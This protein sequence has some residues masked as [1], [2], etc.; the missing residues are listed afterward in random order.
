M[1][2]ALAPLFDLA[3]GVVNRAAAAIWPPR[4]LP[5]L[6]HEIPVSDAHRTLVVVPTLLT[7]PDSVRTVLEHLE[8]H[9]LANIDDNIHFALLGDLKAS[10]EEHASGDAAILEASRSGVE[11]LNERHGAGSAGPFHL[12]VRSRLYNPV[13]SVWMGWERKRGSLTELGRLLRGVGDTSIT[14]QS[15]DSSFLQGVEFVITLDADTIL[16]RD[17]A[18]KLVCTIAHPLSR[19]QVDSGRRGVSR[20]YGLVQPRVGMSL[21][22]AMATLYSRL[23]TGSTGLDPYAGAASDTYQDVFGEGSFTGKG[24]FEVDVF[25]AILEGR[26]PDNRLLSH[27]LIEGCFLRTALVSDVEVLDD[28]PASYLAQSARVHR[29]VRGDWQLLPWL[30]R[31]APGS[32]GARYRNPLSRLHRWKIL[33]NLRRS[34]FPVALLLLGAAGW[35]L[36]PRSGWVWP[37]LLLLVLVFDALMHALDSLLMYPRGVGFRGAIRPVISDLYTDLLRSFVSLSV[38]PHQAYLQCDAAVRALWRSYV[39]K[40]HLLEWTTA[41]EAESLSGSDLRSFSRALLVPALLAVLVMSPALVFMPSSRIFIAPAVITWLASPLVA[42]SISRPTRRDVAA[43]SEADVRY[44]R[45]AARKTW[46][47]FETFVTLEDHW[48]VPDNYQED[49]KGEI[50]HRTSPT[51]MGLQLI[52]ELTAHDLGYTS[53]GVMVDRVSY[54][55]ATMIGLER[56]RGHLYNWYDTLTLEPLRPQYVSTVDSGNLA[57]HLLALRAGLQEV[58]AGPIIGPQALDGFGDALEVALESLVRSKETLGQREIVDGVRREIE[59]LLRRI[60]LSERPHN[61]A[62]WRSTLDDMWR[63]MEPLEGRV[64]GL[65]AADEAIDVVHTV[66]EAVET[67]RRHREDLGTYAPWARQVSEVPHVVAGWTRAFDLAPLLS[68]VPSLVDLAEGLVSTLDALESLISDPVGPDEET[69]AEVAEWATALARDIR[70]NRGPCVELLA[71]LRLMSDVSGEMWAH[72]DF[73]MLYDKGR[74]LFSIGFNMERGE[75]DSSFYDMLASEC[76]LA[77]YLAIAKGEVPQEHWFRLGRQFTRTAGGFALLSWSASMFEYL[78]PQLV[79]N[80]YPDTVLKTT[81]DVVVRR[82]VQYGAERGVP[83]GVSE[84]AFAAKDVELTYQ[85]QAFGVPGLGLK[86]GLSDDVVVAPYAT[87]LALQV[88]RRASLANLRRLSAEG[89]EGPYGF[90][91]SLDYTPGRVPAGK[92]RA[93]VRAYMAHHQGM[94]IVALGNELT[95]GRMRLRFHS[96]P[97]VETAELL[98]QERIPRHIKAAQP[99]VEEVEFVRSLREL[100]PPVTRSYPLANTP[101]PATHFLSNGRYSVMVT[102]AGAGYSRWADMAI[103]RYREDITKD[104]W[105]Q[106]CFIRDVESGEVWSTTYQPSLAPADEYHCVM[107]ADRAEFR[108]IDGE[109]ET[110]SEIVVSPEDDVEVRRVTVTNHG[111]HPRTLELTSYFEIALTT[112]GAEQAHRAFSNLFIETEA[113]PDLRTV[114]FTRRPRSADEER[115]W[116]LHTVSCEGDHDGFGWETDRARFIGRLRHVWA[117]RAIFD[118]LP[119]SGT[120]GPVLDPVC[121]LRKRV[122]IGPGEIVR[123]AFTTGVAASREAALRLAEQ[124]SDVRGAQH[125]IDLSWSMSQIELRDLGV[126]PDEAVVFQ[127]LASRLLLTDPYSRLK[128]KTLHENMLPMSSLWGLGISGD[129]PIMLVKIER[130][131][132]AP[133]VRQSLLAHQYWRHKGF[134]CDLVILNTKPSGYHSELDDR[135]HMLVRTGHALQMLDKPGGVFIRRSDQLTPEV[136]NLLESVARATIEADCGPIVLQLN[137]RG[138]RPELPDPLMPKRSAPVYPV[139]P[140]ERPKLDF[141]NGYGGLDPE[142]GEYVIVLENG[143]A[144]PAPWVNV[145]AGPDFGTM[146]SEAGVG[147]TWAHN[148][149]ENRLTTWNNDAVSDGSGELIYV[150]DEETGEFWSPTQLPM[151]DEAPYVIRHGKGYSTFE[152]ACHGIAHHLTWFV[153]PA[154]PIRVAQLRLTNLSDEPRRLSVTQFVEW[155]LGDSRSKANQRIVTRYDTQGQMLTAHNMFNEDFPGQVAFMTCDSEPC[156]YTASRTEFLGRNGTPADPAAMHRKNL[157]QVTGRFHDNCGAVMAAVGLAAGET[158]E[159]RFLL[160]QCPTVEEAR[161][162]VAEHRAPGSAER[163]LEAVRKQWE[164]ILGSVKV[165]TPDPALDAMVNGQA[166]YQAL[167]CRI[168][169]RTALYQSS[170]AFGFRDQLQDVM[171]L[172]L[173]RPD[174]ARAQIVEASRHQFEAG[175]VQHWW[176]P[177]SGRGV[178]TRITDDRD[179]LPFVVA[180]YIEATGDISVLDETTPFLGGPGLEPGHEDAYSAPTITGHKATVYEHC[181]AALEASRGV[182]PHGLPLIGGGDWNDG[183]NHV[184]IGGQGESVW[185]AWF[186]N[187]TLKRFAQVCAIKGDF[188]R[189]ADYI[190]WAERLAAAT[191]REGWDGAWYRRAYFDDGTALGTRDAD[192]C[193]IDAIAQAW[194]VISGA[195]EPARATRALQAVEEKLVSWENGLIALLT[196]PFDHMAH[197]PGYIK[198]YLPGVRENGGQYTHAAIW[199]VMAYALIGDGDEALGL[200][201]LVNPLNHA[202]TREAADV[203]RVEPYVVAADVYAAPPHVG[204]GGWTWYTGSASWFYN[205]AVRTILGIQTRYEDGQ[206]FLV[207]DPCIPKSWPSFSAE[208]RIGSTTFDVEVTNPRGANRGVARVTV[209]GQAVADGRVPMA[210]DGGRHRVEVAMLGG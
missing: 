85:Y 76:R 64:R 152:H 20:G 12:F 116:G 188:E 179:W 113:V 189:A 166:L 163:A 53:T 169:G 150:R 175:D 173:A 18:R 91:E 30:G 145:I 178:R 147:F 154:Q 16:P 25:N 89:A 93:V 193:R 195:A 68:R 132:D 6:D 105:G 209:D 96:D 125:A 137:Q 7:S 192:E 8:I 29:W 27:D 128:M 146:V 92:R 67:L 164:A 200:L 165:S 13:E 134:R 187:L 168:W 88:D 57:G 182:G 110:L 122:I 37:A 11:A 4:A 38:L 94:S 60:M 21:P 74:E 172:T 144:T 149:H 190:A 191:E 2:L 171:A 23:H 45:R 48:L 9:R 148:S 183:M 120:V 130:L 78:M 28:F 34:L 62:H 201:D 138:V 153:D 50:A 22:S 79:M 40:R 72:T 127:R 140:F 204:R 10:P 43:P 160:G 52:A 86:R 112:Q 118:G 180:D 114:L 77:S 194:S 58:S 108:R 208:V 102:N 156:G 210:Q 141:D 203:Y 106:F 151:V 129:L 104:C 139:P 157:G 55:M 196:P 111:I 124:Y 119:L 142:T 46:R 35:L 143:D 95:G 70:D 19:A 181:V 69:R 161:R 205:V 66:M 170:G 39:S 198:G 1:I 101:T 206:G 186:L 82:Q 32:N 184:G 98:L 5:K 135:L 176:Q 61:L 26:F 117:A 84:S 54:T 131:E 123:L 174:I 42:W 65:H 63:A 87:M 59:E 136:L 14:L 159:V 75:L 167:A 56:H 126:T 207:I 100:P 162:V 158:A 202:L 3:L 97:I 80:T 185:L 51:N 83:W 199:V 15:G 24:I 49:P 115:V 90:Y 121:S 99:H 107:S 197:D 36:I 103:S 71:R 47:F 33:D 133:A 155:V 31:T 44:M 109:I 81:A 177:F 17:A 73:G 41:A